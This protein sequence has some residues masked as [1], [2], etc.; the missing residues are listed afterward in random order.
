[1]RLVPAIS[2]IALV[3]CDKQPAGALA[4]PVEAARCEAKAIR[5]KDFAVL[6]PCL[7]PEIREVADS[8]I[9]RHPIDW[10][11]FGVELDKLEHATAADFKVEPMPAKHANVGDQIA[12]LRFERDSLAVVHA[13]DGHW[14]IEDTGL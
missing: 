14:Y 12:S 2:F 5:A 10:S 9:R 1:M 13:K 7:L 6:R 4:S 11:A 8:E 3:A